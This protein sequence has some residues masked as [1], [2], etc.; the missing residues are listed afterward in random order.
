M[1]GRIEEE[2]GPEEESETESDSTEGTEI[3]DEHDSDAELEEIKDEGDSNPV[4]EAAQKEPEQ[5]GIQETTKAT[6][7]K[8][9]TPNSFLGIFINPTSCVQPYTNMGQ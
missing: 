2:A 8:V 4:S 3:K 5:L 1:I 6:D 9:S 7:S